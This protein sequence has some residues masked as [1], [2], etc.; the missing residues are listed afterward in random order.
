MEVVLIVNP[1]A[2]GVTGSCV[3]DV[4]R[5]LGAVAAVRTLSPAAGHATSSPPRRRGDAVVVFSGDGGYNEVINGVTDEVPL[6]FVPGGGT[7]VLPERSASRASPARGAAGRRGARAR[8][9]AADH[10]RPRQ[11][12][13]V[14]LLGGDRLRRRARAPRGCA[15]PP[16]GRQAAGRPR[17]HARAREVHRGAGAAGSSRR[18]KSG[19][20]PRRLRDRRQLRSLHVRGARCRCTSRP[21]RASSWGSTWSRRSG[22]GR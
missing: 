10:A 5:E 19:A 8:A 12:P 6:G 1:F 11:R 17:L 13:A 18:S 16:R 7:S 3:R 14:Q 9:H 20:R 4:E 22:S 2:S 15:R 21:R